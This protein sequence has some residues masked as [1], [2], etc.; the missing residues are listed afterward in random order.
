MLHHIPQVR[1]KIQSSALASRLATGALWSIAGGI[2][3][4]GL[5]LISFIIIARIIGQEEYGA[6][7]MIRSTVMM[8]ALFAGLGIGNTAS[9]YIALYRNIEPRKTSEIYLLSNFTSLVAGLLFA[10]LLY[11]FAPTVA[12]KSLEA[13]ELT[14]SIRLGAAILFFAALHGA[15]TGALSGFEQFKTISINTTIYGGVQIILLSVGAYFWRIDGVIAAMGLSAFVF[16]GVNRYSLQQYLSKQ[17]YQKIKLK[18]ISRDTIAVLWQFSLPSIMSMVLTIP[19]LWYCKT[20]IVQTSGFSD[21]ANYDVA[22]QWNII[23][24]FIPVTLSGIII[25]ILSNILSEGNMGQFHKTV[26]INIWVNAP[27]TVAAVLFVSLISSLIL[28]SYGAAF[29]DIRTFLVLIAS[30]VP[31]AIAAVLGQIIASKGKMWIGFLLNF[32]WAIWVVLFSLLLIVNMNYGAFGLA[33]AVLFAYILHVIFSYAY[34]YPKV[35]SITVQDS[36]NEK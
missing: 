25:P 7:G 10:L 29:T 5:V 1:T 36:F 2:L 28:K 11:I 18:E 17:P 12:E 15:Q 6:L 22:E 35:K 9:R 4:K 20:L 34:I 13:P 16:W 32:V 31:N 30:T 8:F 14:D 27:I 24:M 19:V 3:G 26:R 23:I 33:L 21:M